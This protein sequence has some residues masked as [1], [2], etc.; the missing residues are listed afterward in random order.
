VAML[1]KS[2][3]FTIRPASEAST[4]LVGTYCS[5]RFVAILEPVTAVSAG[6]AAKVPSLGRKRR[7]LKARFASLTLGT[8]VSLESIFTEVEWL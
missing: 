6:T 1:M 4:I 5:A 7:S 2:F 8:A 3:P